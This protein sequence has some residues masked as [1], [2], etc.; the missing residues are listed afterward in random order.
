[1]ETRFNYTI[2][3]KFDV[4][5]LVHRGEIVKLALE[6]PKVT[7]KQVDE[8]KAKEEQM[9]VLS[10]LEQRRRCTLHSGSSRK[11]QELYQYLYQIVKVL[12]S[13]RRAVS[14]GYLMSIAAQ[15]EEFRAIHQ[16]NHRTQYSDTKHL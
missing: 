11:H 12:R 16:I 13:E 5:N 15:I 14:V 10:E 2:W 3:Q 4:L 6:F 7:Q 1:M 9:R 8:W